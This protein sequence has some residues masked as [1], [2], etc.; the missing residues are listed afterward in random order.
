MR[1]LCLCLT[2]LGAINWLLIGLF[3]FNFVEMLFGQGIL[4][5]IIYV[6]IGICGIVNIMMLFDSKE[7]DILIEE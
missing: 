5:R 2:I 7:S 3:G 1:K 6:I 4:T